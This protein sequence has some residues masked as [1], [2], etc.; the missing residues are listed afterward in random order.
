MTRKPEPPGAAAARKRKERK[1]KR[2]NGLETVPVVVPAEMKQAIKDIAKSM[3]DGWEPDRQEMPQ[4]R[5][6]RFCAT[7]TDGNVISVTAIPA[8]ET[9]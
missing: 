5:Y 9:T 2:E 3:L 7:I 1:L 6:V 4:S 8:K